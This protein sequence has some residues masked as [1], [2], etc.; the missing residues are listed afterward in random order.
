MENSNT[1]TN[2][3]YYLEVSQDAYDI[4]N[5]ACRGMEQLMCGN[6]EGLQE[7]AF[8]AF[9]KR[10]GTEVPQEMQRQIKDCIKGLAS[11]GWNRPL[12]TVNR[13]NDESD[14]LRDIADVL[15]HQQFI[16]GNESKSEGL[17]PHYNKDV[18]QIRI[19]NVVESSQKRNKALKIFVEGKTKKRRI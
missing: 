7:M 2:T 18:P 19:I 16:L 9:E 15:D 10:T 14:A 6:L 8:A 13:F 3:F 4:L 12:E 11:W 1:K 5:R 17:P